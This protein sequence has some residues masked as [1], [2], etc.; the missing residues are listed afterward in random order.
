MK[1]A[2]LLFVVTILV[3]NVQ[4]QNP[5]K[6]EFRAAWMATYSNIDWPAVGATTAQEQSTFIQRVNEHKLNGMNALFVQIRSQCDAM[7]ASSFEPW[8]KD[9][10]G[11]QGVAPS[12]YY[13]PLEFM[14]TETRKKGMEFHAWMNPY[15][16]LASATTSNINALSSTHVINAHPS[17]ILDCTTNSNGAVQKILNPGLPQ[18]WD[19]V[20]SVVMDVVR[21][22]DVDGIHFDDY[23][24]TNPASTTYNDDATFLANSR[25]IS[26]KADWRRS[27]VD[28]LIKRLNDSIKSVKP[29]V[30]FGVSP[31]GIWLSNTT[32]P[33]NPAGSATSSGATQHY[34]DH[35]ANSRLWQ[36]QGWV[37]YMIPQIYWFMGQSG[38]SY[39]VLAPWWNN[40][41]FN[42]HMYIGIAGYK[43]GDVD[44]GNFATNNQEIP[45]QIRLN[46][47]NANIT[48]H[49]IYNTTSLRNNPLGFRDSLRNFFFNKPALL[50]TM[51]WKDNVAPE[52]AT[53]LVASQVFLN[54][55]T[56][57][58]VKPALAVNEMDKVKRFA[59]YRSTTFPVDITNANNLIY[60]SPADEV[61]YTD[62]TVGQGVNYYYVVTAL[63][64]LHNESIVSNTASIL[65]LPMQLV[66]FAVQKN[67]S[68]TALIKF[69]TN[70]EINVSY[71]EVEKAGIAQTFKSIATI[72]A[73]NNAITNSYTLIDTVQNG[74]WLYRIKM[75]DKDGTTTYSS[76][77]TYNNSTKNEWI[78]VYPT[79]I[80]KGERLKVEVSNNSSRINYSMMNVN[81]IVVQKGILNN[82][83]I[84]LNATLQSGMYII[85]L[86]DELGKQ[87][88]V[89]IIV[90]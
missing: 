79:V 6:R 61:T 72:A 35:F 42:R 52:P 47:Q 29:W 23:F 41:A 11:T 85:L 82:N 74:K 81:G 51:S 24:Y 25:G 32:S 68:N 4:A 73:K 89:N 16:A 26:N 77:I 14:I 58:W 5:P 3:Q 40:N 86:S 53:N 18:V 87:E 7:Y 37:D 1:Q 66:D 64:R 71:F 44:Q 48:G 36:N 83:F 20:I 78:K 19:Y 84:Q 17:W 2:F 28:T 60:I 90:Q 54:T 55:I 67:N 13:D 22:Y 21:R 57:N 43:V 30:K 69:I 34:K 49:V 39:T 50:P 38:S 65:A 59:L 70:N 76:V 62:Y 33:V 56:L 10:T 45:N 80:G 9:L 15:R 8:S 88:Q 46:R 27:N 75:V 63:D 31:S 12:P